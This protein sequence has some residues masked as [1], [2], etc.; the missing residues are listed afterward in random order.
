[1]NTTFQTRLEALQTAHQELVTRPNEKLALGNGVIDRY[2]YP[3]LTA[4]HAPLF[5]RYD[6][7]PETNPF[8]MERFG[9]NAAFNAG[10]IKLNGKYLMVVRVEGSDR[11][12]F[13]AV[14]ESD[15]GI[16]NFR[17]W[18]RPITMPET[19]NPDVNVYDMRVTQ[20]EDGWIYGVFC[21]ERKDPDAKPGDESSAVAQAGIARTRD[22]VNWERLPDLKTPSPQQRNV[23]LHP[24][25]VNGRYAFYTRP[26]DGFIEAGTGG[27]IGFGLADTIENA[28]VEKELIV[29]QKQYH[30]VY[31]VKNGQGPAPIKTEKGWLH[32]AHGVR[33][34]AAGLRYV[35]YMFM[36]DLE[37]LTK[38]IYKPGGYFIAPEGEERIGDVSNVT[39]ANGWILDDDGTVFIY[40]GSS[41]TRMHV[42]T[43]TVEQLLDYV[44]HTPE[45]KFR[46][47]ASVQQINRIIDHNLAFLEAKGKSLAT[48]ESAS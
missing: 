37:D 32:M 30:T 35:L 4:Q 34:T 41:D 43:S 38:V 5:W 13:F 18:D 19:E 27:G 15:N 23:V 9:I 44:V 42:A 6:L 28:V 29:D 46:S 25:F 8:L 22:L 24:E 45:D 40:Y 12:S 36:T 3:A 33:N 7:N 21:T 16:D 39:F 31:E 17:F 11:K 2:K 47:A 14:A 1:M 10:A 48:L 20:H 26:Q